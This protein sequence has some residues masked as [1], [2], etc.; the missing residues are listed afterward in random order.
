M[1]LSAI[2][3]LWILVVGAGISFVL[4]GL[5]RNSEYASKVWVFVGCCFLGL[6]WQGW[7]CAG[8]LGKQLRV[9]EEGKEMVVVGK[10]SDIP[11]CDKEHCSFSFVVDSDGRKFRLSWYG[12]VKA[13]HVGESW[14]LFVRLKRAHGN[15]NPGGFDSEAWSWQQHFSG[16]GYV[17][18]KATNEYLGVSSGYGFLRW[19]ERL[20]A[21]CKKVL[22]HDPLAGIVTALNLGWT[23]DIPY[24]QKVT[25]QRTGTA[26]LLAISGLHVGMVAALVFW[27]TCG[28]WSKIHRVT[29]LIPSPMIGA[30]FAI[31]AAIIY[32]EMAGF[33]CSTQR[34]CVMCAILLLPK[35]AHRHMSVKTALFRAVWVVLLWDP[36]VVMSSGFWL[37]FGAVFV[38]IYA[39][40]Y[41][42][43]CPKSNSDCSAGSFDLNNLLLIVQKVAHK[44]IKE[45]IQ[46][47]QTQW[48]CL[49]GLLPLS[50]WY[51]HQVSL[52]SLVSNLIAIPLMGVLILPLVLLGTA[53]VN[54]NVYLAKLFFSCATYL[55]ALLGVS[56]Q[57]LSQQQWAVWNYSFTH[58]WEIVVVF[59]GCALLVFT[60]KN[61]RWVGLVGLVPLALP[62]TFPVQVGQFKLSVL[63][64][65]QG[66]ATVVTTRNH[67]VIYDTGAKFSPQ[68]DCGQQI[69]VPYLINEKIH[70]IDALILS[71]G[72]NDH[73]GGASAVVRSF[74]VKKIYTSAVDKINQQLNEQASAVKISECNRGITWKWDGVRFEFLHPD[75]NVEG[76]ANDKSCVLKVSS[77][78]GSVLFTGDIEKTAE[79][80]LTQQHAEQLSS[81][82]L[83]APHHG[84]KTS[85]TSDFLAAV[86]PTVAILSYGYRNR[87]R[88]PNK[89]VVERYLKKGTQL[90][91]TVTSGAI[92]YT[93][94]G[95]R[96]WRHYRAS[97]SEFWRPSGI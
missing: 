51:F 79:R 60:Q 48:I 25:A 55:L 7:H 21:N 20:L 64:V 88:H 22:G 83:I 34:A 11:V 12:L 57:W 6:F 23:Q 96:Q 71:H 81:S 69:V 30:L 54:T 97:H 58:V 49:I 35:F 18:N 43:K 4:G 63:D 52:V 66:L 77:D 36:C 82:I 72:D 75:S 44:K 14:K 67:A 10:V 80:W 2:P 29:E 33:A 73:A 16:K 26:H 13:V 1:Q 56:L 8:L 31:F 87:Y 93:I 70:Q 85:S 3:K 59:S 90:F 39:Q 46:L 42:P 19:R 15:L 27:L 89:E 37:S 95:D 24:F 17:V 76:K 91:D 86:H 65:G 94:G 40:Y 9:G 84:S 74:T 47:L 28:L 92:S 53:L 41:S 32:S 61:W 50:C 45:F 78:Y 68:L 62:N 38:L 5:Y